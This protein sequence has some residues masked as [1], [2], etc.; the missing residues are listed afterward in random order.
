MLNI[1]PMHNLIEYTDNYSKTSGSL[2]QYYRY[3]SFLDN[4]GAIA[5][6]PVDNNHTVLS[7]IVNEAIKTIL[8]FLRRDFKRKKTQNKQF[9]PSYEVF[10]RGKLLL[11][12][13]NIRLFLFC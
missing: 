12:L 9:S 6:F 10:V 11:L 7:S 5:D 2:W 13:F 8:I 3:E 1:L 4:N